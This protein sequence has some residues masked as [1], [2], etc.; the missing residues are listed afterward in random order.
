MPCSAA[1][2]YLRLGAED[3]YEGS[4]ERLDRIGSCLAATDRHAL[5]HSLYMR[6]KL[7]EAIA[8]P[9]F[10]HATNLPIYI[11]NPTDEGPTTGQLLGQVY[12]RTPAEVDAEQENV[13]LFRK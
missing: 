13:P 8:A 4:D 3:L 1:K 12:C 10:P 5:R 11:E 9:I 2:R 6:R 7:G